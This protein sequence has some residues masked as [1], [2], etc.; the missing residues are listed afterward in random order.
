MIALVIALTVSAQELVDLKE[1]V[2][3]IDLDIRYATN[4][5]FMGEKVNSYKAPKC[6]VSPK[7]A[8]ALNKIQQELVPKG[9]SLKMYDCYRPVSA[10]QQFGKWAEG[11]K[12]GI[13]TF[14]PNVQKTKLF[15]KGYIA[16]RSGHSDGNTVDLTIIQIS[17]RHKTT[18]DMSKK[19]TDSMMDNSIDMG[20][21]F[22][23][24]DEKSWTAS[25][26]ISPKQGARRDWLKN[27]MEKNGFKNYY[28]EWWHYK[29]QNDPNDGSQ[30]NTDIK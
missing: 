26:A 13:S 16:W 7:T 14:F 11:A 27:L 5:N 15:E 17:D 21:A 30:F 12:P 6:L 4:M 3:T 25:M 22:D 9:F 1:K 8:A 23:C 24:F 10:V 18:I 28:Q 19:C 20:T 2:P 29:M